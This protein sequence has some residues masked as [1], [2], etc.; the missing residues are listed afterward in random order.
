MSEAA[1][2]AATASVPK[3]DVLALHAS[4]KQARSSRRPPLQFDAIYPTQ[5]TNVAR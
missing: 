4:S 1:A 5:P 3:K 2:A